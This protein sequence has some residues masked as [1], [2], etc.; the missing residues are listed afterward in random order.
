MPWMFIMCMY[1]LMCIYCLVSSVK[2]LVNQA[3]TTWHS[4]CIFSISSLGKQ[5]E[6]EYQALTSRISEK[7]CI[8]KWD[9]RVSLKYWLQTAYAGNDSLPITQ[10]LLNRSKRILS[11]SRL[12]NKT[13][14]QKTSKQTKTN[15]A[16]N[17]HASD[18]EKAL[19]GQGRKIYNA[20]KEMSYDLGKADKKTQ[21]FIQIWLWET[22]YTKN[23]EDKLE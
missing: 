19:C 22:R 17:P 9:W 23:L 3:R 15:P 11:Q 6:K 2:L 7:F 12:Q 1:F 18:I 21:N 5:Q 13:L 10:H 20:D 14:P 8:R 16:L 4:G